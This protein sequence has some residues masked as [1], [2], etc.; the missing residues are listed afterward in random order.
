MIRHAK[1]LPY[2]RLQ[3]NAA[4]A[5]HALPVAVGTCHDQY[6][7]FS[8]LVRCKE[9]DR[10]VSPLITQA[11]PIAL[12]QRPSPQGF[13]SR[14]APAVTFAHR[15]TFSNP[16]SQDRVRTG[17]PRHFTDEANRITSGISRIEYYSS[18]CRGKYPKCWPF[19]R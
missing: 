15:S 19:L 11:S 3:I 1:V 12:N 4:P 18:N 7:E 6:H 10:G 17:R 16:P 9:A 14:P 13:P 5:D 8:L 2:H